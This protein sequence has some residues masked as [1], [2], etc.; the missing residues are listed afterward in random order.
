M[1]AL[2]FQ[3]I[4]V[5]APP[6]PPK[7][8]AI[9]ILEQS[10][11]LSNRTHPPAPVPEGGPRVSSTGATGPTLGP[12]AFPAQPEPRRLDGSPFW[13]PPAVY[14][15]IPFSFFEVPFWSMAPPCQKCNTHDSG[16]KPPDHKVAGNVQ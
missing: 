5:Q 7:A 2:L 14:G 13:L 4:L 15:Q 1:I 3:L 10:P 12:W 11:G 9:R 8:E 6:P 16:Q